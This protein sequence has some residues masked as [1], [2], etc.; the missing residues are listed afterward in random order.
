MPRGQQYLLRTRAFITVKIRLKEQVFWG[1]RL[2]L[3]LY[4]GC[5]LQNQPENVQIM[6]L[7]CS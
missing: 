7:K 4:I 6:F 2:I 1:F 3:F 5:F